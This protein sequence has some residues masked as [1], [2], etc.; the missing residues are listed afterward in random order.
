MTGIFE[1]I[2]RRFKADTALVAAGRKLY[3][4]LN[5]QRQKTLPYVDVK[6]GPVDTE[7]DTFDDD[8]DTYNL[9]FEVVTREGRDTA[10]ADAL[11]HLRRVFK[12]ADLL[13]EQYRTVS[14][15]L[16]GGDGPDLEEGI[17]VG[18]ASYELIVQR[19]VLLPTVRES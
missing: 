19:K 8:V 3:L 4:G 9:D 13:S 14:M 1:S 15:R 2:E 5:G 6:I 18:R 11:Q 7:L 12:A 10:A 16:T 17:Y